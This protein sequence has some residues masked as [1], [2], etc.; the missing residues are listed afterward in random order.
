MQ[1]NT[2]DI[3]TEIEL[4]HKSGRF[5]QTHSSRKCNQPFSLIFKSEHRLYQ[6]PLSSLPTIDHFQ[7]VKR[8]VRKRKATWEGARNEPSMT[9]K[10]HI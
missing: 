6:F 4:W 2:P 9:G 8:F 1:V 7:I 5:Y 10:N 3:L